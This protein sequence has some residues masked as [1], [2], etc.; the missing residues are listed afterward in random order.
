MRVSFAPSSRLMRM[1]RI[2]IASLALPVL[3]SFTS[4]SSMT[5]K[6]SPLR[7]RTGRQRVARKRALTFWRVTNKAPAS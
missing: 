5:V 6:P 7:L 3:T 1:R 4:A 2:G